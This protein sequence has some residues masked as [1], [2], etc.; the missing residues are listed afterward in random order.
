MFGI[1]CLAFLALR[2]LGKGTPTNDLRNHQPQRT[3]EGRQYSTLGFKTRP[4]E[5][6]VLPFLP[7]GYCTQW[8]GFK[9][10]IQRPGS[11]SSGHLLT[12]LFHPDEDG[13]E[14]SFWTGMDGVRGQGTGGNPKCPHLQAVG[15]HTGCLCR[16]EPHLHSTLPPSSSGW[17]CSCH[18]VPQRRIL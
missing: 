14:M 11:Q 10:S 13:Y 18:R 6:R 17:R 15:R 7:S 5:L 16:I 2:V 1:C 9:G 3:W 4:S 12:H 8:R